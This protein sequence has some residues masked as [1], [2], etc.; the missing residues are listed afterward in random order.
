MNTDLQ[1]VDRT[2]TCLGCGTVHNRD[3]NAA[4]NIKL[5]GMRLLAGSG[6]LGVTPVEEEALAEA[7][8]SANP[9]SG[10]AGTFYVFLQE[11]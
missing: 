11:R 3:K 2:W 7:S 1:L 4:I 9:C 6:Y 10:E 8:A 5:E